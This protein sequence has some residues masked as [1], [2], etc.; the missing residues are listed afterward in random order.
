MFDR[1]AFSLRLIAV[2]AS[3]LLLSV[4]EALVSASFQ[5]SFAA[6]A[7]LIAAFEASRPMWQR[8]SA[9]PSILR[10]VGLWVLSMAM[11]SIIA[12]LA[13]S[14]FSLFHFQKTAMY[15]LFSNFIVVPLMGV[16]VMPLYFVALIL[17]PLGLD[18]PVWQ[19]IGWGMDIT[20]LTASSVA[21]WPYAV[22]GFASW[23]QSAMIALA[24]GGYL[25]I[26]L[27]GWHRVLVLVPCVL[28][29]GWIAGGVRPDILITQDFKLIGWNTQN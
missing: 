15:S 26:V 14:P 10:R 3:I 18:W 27:K 25:L 11:T 4:P 7:A 16:M 1:S 24:V 2:A 22:I 6:V 13:T 19:M 12:T 17:M 8:V 9:N 5:M 29:V 28:A 21:S 20:L 23:P